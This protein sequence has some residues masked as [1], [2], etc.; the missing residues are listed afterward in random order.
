VLLVIAFSD[1]LAQKNTTLTS[2]SDSSKKAKF[3]LLE[4]RSF[5]DN[6]AGYTF[7]SDDKPFVDVTL[8]LRT[9]IFP[10]DYLVNF[11]PKI[12][13]PDLSLH[14]AFTGRFAQYVGTRHSNPVVEKRFNPY[15]FLEFRPFKKYSN[16]LMQTGYGH[17]SNGQSIDDSA[18]FYITA[19][20]PYNNI[21]ETKDKISRGWDYV[22]TA[23]KMDIY[24]K[25]HAQLIYEMEIGMRY[26]LDRGFLQNG[27][28]EYHTWERDWYGAK[29]TRNNVAGISASFTCF[30]DSS[31]I[32]K[33]RVTFETGISRPFTASTI[34]ILLGFR[35]GN[36]PVSFSY[37]YGYNGD[38]AQY[39]KSTSSIGIESLLPSFQRPEDKRKRRTN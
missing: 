4:L 31:F 16:L 10:F 22:G 19:M 9:R 37:R 28:E 33:M 30:V 38:F 26:F 17:E 25:K 2:A 15:M 27:K 14:F 29:Y 23:V 32:N 36:F 3:K 13:R 20:L 18:T 35:I 21:N 6:I 5:E 7:E 12:Y 39:G 24:P 1:L 8:S 34:K 11:L